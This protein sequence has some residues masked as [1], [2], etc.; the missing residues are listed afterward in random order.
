MKRSEKTAKAYHS[1]KTELARYFG[2]T[3]GEMHE[4]LLIMFALIDVTETEYLVE[5]T[6]YMSEERMQMLIENIWQWAVS[7][8]TPIS[9]YKTISEQTQIKRIEKWNRNK[10]K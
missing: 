6:K 5:S 4:W 8:G 3:P 9:D 7:R 2:Y 10:A 1:L